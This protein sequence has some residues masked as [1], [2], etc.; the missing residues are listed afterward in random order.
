MYHQTALERADEFKRRTERPE[1]GLP[2]QLDQQKAA[3]VERNRAVLK[4]VAQAVLYCGKQCIA[5]RGS[6]EQL[7]TEGN[8]GNFLALL[9]LLSDHNDI[10][11]KHLE[12][13][14]MRNAKYISP[15]TQNELIEVIGKNIILCKVVDEIKAA[16]FYSVL[17]DEVTSHNEEHLAICICFVDRNKEVR[18]EFVSFIHLQRITGE[19][20]ADE[21]MAFLQ[22]NGIQLPDMR[23]QGYDGASN[24][25][26][27]RSGVQAR[28]LQEAPLATYVHCSSHCL[29]L[30]IVKSC[31]LTDITHV[32][33]R[34]QY[35]CKSFLNSPKC[36]GLLNLVISENVPDA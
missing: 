25:S 27:S 15:R 34:L 5:L 26:G 7:D 1:V 30:V 23:R 17:A 35:C 31:S 9:K 13:P 6:I 22:N 10:L 33:E 18:E 2:A 19:K 24:M 32:L 21:L 12:T 3:N 14:A 4:T 28:I 16:K 20:I 29:N 11:Q 8:P 36:S